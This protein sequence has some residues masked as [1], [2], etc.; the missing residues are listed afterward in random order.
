[1]DNEM[2]V[3]QPLQQK[4]MHF[5][6]GLIGLED[7]KKFFLKELTGH[8]HFFLLQSVDDEDFGLV[9]TNPFWFIPE[10][11]FDLDDV[12]LEQLADKTNLEVFVTITLGATADKITANLMGPIVLDRKLG[13]G[14][15]VLVSDK[16]YTTR[17]KLMSAQPAGG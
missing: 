5:P 4:M 15:Q 10:Y 16:N 2:S 12:Y 9:I 1:M 8:E 3:L 17:Y 11:E 14:F 13:I 7:Y 6:H